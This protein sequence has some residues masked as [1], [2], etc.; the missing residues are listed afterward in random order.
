[1]EILV[2][3]DFVESINYREFNELQLFRTVNLKNWEFQHKK[4]KESSI[5]KTLNF[6]N[7]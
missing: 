2:K 7:L 6:R 3:R 4:I 5:L 1:M